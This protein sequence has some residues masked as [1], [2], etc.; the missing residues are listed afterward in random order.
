MMLPLLL[1]AAF[2]ADPISWIEQQGGTITRGS[3]N[4]ITGVSLA[5]TW[6]TDNDLERLTGLTSL[7]SLDLSHTYVTDRGIERLQQFKN[8][9]EL[10]LDTAEFLTDAAM[11]YLRANKQL[12][13]LSVRGVDITDV[14]LPYIGELTKLKSLDLSHS[15][16][17]DVGLES[18]PTLTELEDLDIGATRITGINLNFLK[19]LPNLKRLNIRGIQRRNGGACWSPQL[20]D[21]DMDTIAMLTKLESLDVGVGLSLAR[22]GKPLGGGNNCRLAGGIQITDLGLAK[23]TKLKNLK[24][25]EVSGSKLTNDGL[26]PLLTLP[27]LER[28]SLWNCKALDDKAVETLGRLKTLR[29]LDV[30]DTAITPEGLKKLASSLPNLQYLY[31]SVP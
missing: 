19:L 27:N 15:M 5:R 9:T 12:T 8:L 14:G 24:R 7:T 23:L 1:S 13:R 28:L 20:T 22:N 29:F 6:A 30:S 2:A 4:T 21:L 10:N 11:N 3:N 18:L 31:P 16:L 25:L 17:G 26:K